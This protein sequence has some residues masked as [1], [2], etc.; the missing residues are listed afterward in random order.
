MQK[1]KVITL[2]DD[3]DAVL[4]SLDEAGIVQFI[5]MREKL[6]DWKGVLVS[7]VVP[8]EVL[9]KCSDLL[10]K[11]DASLENLGLKREELPSKEI[12][13]TRKTMEE[14]L[15]RVEQKLA[16]LPVEALTKCSVLTARID[17]LSEIL[18]VRPEEV[19]IEE[20]ALKKP[21]EE[22]LAEIE[23]ELSEI[24]KTA[25]TTGLIDRHAMVDR[26]KTVA[27]REEIDVHKKLAEFAR[28]RMI[29]S[30]PFFAKRLLTLKKLVETAKESIE[31]E[32]QIGKIHESLL[33]LRKTVEREKQ[34][35]EEQKKFVRS[36]KTI[37]FEAWVPEYDVKEAIEKIKKN[38]DKN[39][40]VT[41]E[42]PAPKEKVPVILKPGPSYLKAFEKLVYSF[43]YP[44]SGDVNP[45]RVLAITFPLLFGIMF[46]DV[47]QGAIFAVV[48]VILTFLRR[49]VKLEEVGDI[50]QY[51]LISGEMFIFL[52]I[53]AIFFGFIFGEFFGPSGLI[54]PICLG[55]IGPFYIGGFEPT[56]EPMKMLKFAIFVGAIHISLGL[57]FRFINEIR[58]KHYKLAPIPICWLWL[59][60][61]SLYMW[62]YWRGISNI[63]KWFA[64]GSL[65]L[66]GLLI[67]PLAL[68]LVFTGVAEGFM[69]GVGFSVEVFAETLSHSM[70]Y[71]RLMALG[72]I[73]SAMNYL[74][75]VLAG[76]EHGH[77]PLESI[78][79]I[80]IGT[81]LVMVIE[82]LVVF[83]HTLRLHW[84]EWF[85]KFHTGEGIPFKPF[86]YT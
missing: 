9:T 1:L 77:F 43:G 49:R 19:K 20:G 15:D 18:G 56:Q 83:V 25:E 34:I 40:I 33:T 53:S 62:A 21:V 26:I 45:I 60:I 2:E 30:K 16:K 72:L 6:E 41:E 51:L 27:A 4:R 74:F 12:P 79:M 17:Q 47:G 13:V 63:S 75:L 28:L 48:G 44:S 64:E 23:Y 61:G 14:V 78:P 37:Y 3:V 54:H 46:A 65:M 71:S 36:A 5:D 22:G 7:Q 8:P 50:I 69:E 81:L 76:V 59:L 11:I 73:H 31:E 67:V 57:V 52:G 84:V 10:L 82:G 86:K 29:E 85:S 80:A 55:K 38:T 58:H 35:A 66:A 70:S 42:A 39:S 68:I 24:E 32:T